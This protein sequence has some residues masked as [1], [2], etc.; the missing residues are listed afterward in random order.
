[1]RARKN[2]LICAALAALFAFSDVSASAA[3]AWFGE[4]MA[5]CAPSIHPQTGSALVDRE[6]AFDPLVIHVNAAGTDLGQVVHPSDVANAVKVATDFLAK[7]RSIDL[8]LGQINSDN[9]QRLGLTPATAFDICRNL[10]AMG[11]VLQEGY[12]RY[13]AKGYPAQAA[14]DA[15]LSTYNTG[16]SSGG[17]ANGYV[18]EV[19]KRADS[20]AYVVPAI[21]A[22]LDQSAAPASPAASTPPAPPARWDVFGDMSSGAPA[23][24]VLISGRHRPQAEAEPAPAQPGPTTPTGPVRQAGAVLVFAEPDQSPERNAPVIPKPGR[25]TDAER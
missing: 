2:A 22:Q 3:P 16:N 13:L 4:A 24:P 12:E 8:G 19:R 20:G 15:A 5:R 9:L 6:S 11:V 14:L 21:N 18:A 23:D 25:P 10:T 7:G 1:M 17:M